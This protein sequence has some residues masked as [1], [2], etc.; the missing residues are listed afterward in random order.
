LKGLVKSEQAKR[1]ELQLEVK[2]K[3]EE[4]T[5]FIRKL[6][7]ETQTLTEQ[8]YNWQ[9]HISFLHKEHNKDFDKIYKLN[10]KEIIDLQDGYNLGMWFRENK[11]APTDD[12]YSSE[13]KN[14]GN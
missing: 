6:K 9:K 7:E 5:Y 14:D 12:F 11:I 2:E 8:I 10:L 13:V 3:Q 4:R 1:I